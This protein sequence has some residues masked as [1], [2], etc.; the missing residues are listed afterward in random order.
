MT[1]QLDLYLFTIRENKQVLFSPSDIL[2]SSEANSGDRVRQFVAW[3]SRRQNRV[4]AW[5]GRVL[6]AA[7][8]YYVQLEDKI[9]PVERVLKVMDGSK[10]MIVYHSPAL[11][12]ADPSKVAERFARLL[13]RQRWKHLFWISLDTILCA[14]TPF[15][16]PIPGPNVFFYYPFLRWLSHYGAI[17]GAASG[18]RSQSI[19]FKCL[20]ELGSLEENLQTRS[21]DFDAVRASEERLNIRGLVSFLERMV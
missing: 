16:I 13:T 5:F 20:P 21:A 10:R 14:F 11:D 19:E 7:H 12:S 3:F 15:L 8:A 9:D 6:A 17:R 1:E 18:L 2:E 4:A